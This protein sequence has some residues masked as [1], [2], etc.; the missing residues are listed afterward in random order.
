V[1]SM[2]FDWRRDY[3][4]R[5]RHGRVVGGPAVRK[6]C[7]NVPV[8]RST[9]QGWLDQLAAA[10]SEPAYLPLPPSTTITDETDPEPRFLTLA[11]M[12][13]DPYS[14]WRARAEIS[15]DG[16]LRFRVFTSTDETVHTEHVDPWLLAWLRLYWSG[17]PDEPEQFRALL[18]LA[19][20]PPS[21][22]SR[23]DSRSMGS[24]LRLGGAWRIQR[25]HT[26]LQ[27]CSTPTERF[28]NERYC[29][30]R[31]RALANLVRPERQS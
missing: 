20:T 14:T 28:A 8:A 26:W 24:R 1:L 27:P 19:R 6:R 30:S 3:K 21:T 7:I 29:C 12:P 11:A 18:E 22:C 2:P 31:R 15:T 25:R 23:T 5:I 16:V 10:R 13:A 9:L 4:Y 17:A